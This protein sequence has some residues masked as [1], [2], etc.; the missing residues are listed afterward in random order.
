MIERSKGTTKE[1]FHEFTLH[2]QK[3]LLFKN[4]PCVTSPAKIQ[5]KTKYIC[6]EV[7]MLKCT[8]KVLIFILTVMSSGQLFLINQFDSFIIIP[9]FKKLLPF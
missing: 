5:N 7:N 3:K 2:L 1:K 6:L 9:A 4:F 8:G